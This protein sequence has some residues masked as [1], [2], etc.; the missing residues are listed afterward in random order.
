MSASEGYQWRRDKDGLG[1]WEHRGKVAVAGVGHSPVDRRWDEVSMDQTVGAYSILACR[2]AMDEAGVTPDQ[3]EGVI[4]CDS[5]IAGGSGG[6][7]SQWAPRP[8]FAPPY[9]SEWG[10]TLVNAQ[11][12]IAQM[13]LPN[14]KFAPTGVPTI[15]EMVGMAAQ[16]VGDGQCHTCLVIYPTGNLEGRYRRGGE[17]ADD[18]ARGARQWTAPWGNHGGN[19][20]INIFPHNQ[21]CL[22]YGGQHDDLAPF[23]VNQHRN[24][25][26]TPWGYNATH[27]V[28]QL[29]IEDYVNSRYILNP[30][31][32]W[33]CDRPV[34]AST[35]YL[36][37]TAERA[38]DMRQPPVYVLNHSQHNFRKRSTQEDLDEIEDWTDRA[39]Q[40]M[41]EGA[42]LGP[43]GRR[44]LQSL[45]RLCPDGAVL[46]R[47]LP[48]ARRQTR[49]RLRVL[50]RRHQG[51]GAA[52][53]LLERRQSRDR[54]PAH[55]HVHR[56]HRAAP[57]HGR[58]PPGQGSGRDSA[59][60]LHHAKQ[61]RL[62]HVRQIPELTAC[63]NNAGRDDGAGPAADSE[64]T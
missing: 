35:A 8:Y 1:V 26:L 10:L 55:R 15:S 31:R 17:N 22:K 20:F 16:A 2:K 58:R 5:H 45:R 48:V 36:F 14:V 23:V 29:T 40:R 63:D 60:G 30:L 24:G 11:W 34:N 6:S 3:I 27:N 46:P 18:Y 43:A 57:R 25:L 61:W 33:D 59:G 32:L 28:P 51:R 9:D 38:R 53:V 13:R 7:A 47:G 64:Q 49:R 37:T 62:D 12:L 44:Y 56:Q 50:R 54:A 39:A 41:Y 19:D 21:Y 4:C 52:P 42:G